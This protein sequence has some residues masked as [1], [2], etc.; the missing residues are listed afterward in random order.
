MRYFIQLSYKGTDY[1]GWQIQPNGPSIQEALNK[2]LCTILRTEIYVVGAGRTDTGVHARQMFAHF[3]VDAP[4]D[5][6]HLAF[7]LNRMLPS[8]IAVQKLFEV[9]EGTHARF[10]AISRSYEYIICQEKNPFLT[11]WAWFI[12]QP[13]SI[14]A[15]NEGAK[16]LL[17]EQDFSCFSKSRTQ[18]KTNVC[19]IT[20][21]E[22]RLEKDNLVFNISAN[23]FLR[24]M[25]RAIV[26]T[27]VDVGQNKISIAEF[28]EVLYAKDRQKA[29]TSAPAQGLYLTQIN[30]PKNIL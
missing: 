9:P 14:D 22:W 10:D 6:T 15:M 11:D 27:L 13:I 5:T 3:D 8:A 25:V 23:R 1:C 16:L 24:N 20:H 29:G 4:I 28:K 30:Y 18:T 2:A 19:H 7:R 26:G 17:G 21:A 12:E